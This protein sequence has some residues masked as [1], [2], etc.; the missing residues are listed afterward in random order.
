MRRQVDGLVI[1]VLALGVGVVV[2]PA[3]HAQEQV[4][5]DTPA[6]V[7]AI[8]AANAAKARVRLL[9]APK[10]GYSL[11]TPL[12][13]N[14]LPV[15]TGDVELVG[16]GTTIGRDRRAPRFRVLEVAAGGALGL[17]GLTISGGHTRDAVEHGGSGEDGGGVLN[18]GTL[19]LDRVEVSGN[20]AGSGA[21]GAP[22]NPGDTGET[23]GW[24]GSGGGVATSGEAVLRV[25][26]SVV[27]GN[28]AGDGGRGGDGVGAT[29]SG[30][31]AEGGNGGTGGVGGGLAVTGTVELVDSV[32]RDNHTGGGGAGGNGARGADKPTGAGGDGG[33][34]GAG[35][36]GGAG[37]GVFS[38]AALTA[39]RTGAFDNT[40]GAGGPAGNGGRGGDGLTGGAGGPEGN[41]FVH[42]GGNGGDGG[43][44]AFAS[45]PTALSASDAGRNRTG[46]GGRGGRGGDGGTPNGQAGSGAPGGDGGRGAGLALV[47]GGGAEVVTVSGGT[48]SDNTTGDGAAGADS[49][50]GNADYLTYGNG[51][52][53]GD[54]GKGGGVHVDKKRRLTVDGTTI[55]QNRTGAGATGGQV[56]SAG[57]RPGTPG[58]RGRGGGVG[59]SYYIDTP[60]SIV[61]TNAHVLA[62]QPDDCSFRST[63][64]C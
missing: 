2:A 57:G 34:P 44:W 50:R 32:V 53:G 24:G 23:G 54:G 58:L 11:T 49:G 31:G 25:R 4:P 52:S 5:C 40:T 35:G 63:P 1:G 60:P 13:A 33:Q 18:A 8:T 45:T 38:A 42:T 12:G 16:Q 43:G 10:C 61:L 28:S 59:A 3:A 55:R 15:I 30:H 64:D 20:R 37:G 19:V 51:G 47:K 21:P 7:K 14:G 6:L 46:A 9:L 39:T 62:N 17:T 36:D 26:R 27:R 22:G 41:K 29:S 48:L 56:R